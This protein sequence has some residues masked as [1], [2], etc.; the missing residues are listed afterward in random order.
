MKLGRNWSG[1]GGGATVAEGVR[2][3]SVPL[4]HAHDGPRGAAGDALLGVA[5]AGGGSLDETSP[6]RRPSGFAAVLNT[7]QFNTQVRHCITEMLVAPPP[8]QYSN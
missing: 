8:H 3:A 2:V 4:A 1:S 7:P 6:L 5:P